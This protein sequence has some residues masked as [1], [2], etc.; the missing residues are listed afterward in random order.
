[1]RIHPKRYSWWSHR[2]HDTRTS[3]LWLGWQSTHCYSHPGRTKQ[4]KM[5]T[6]HVSDRIRRNLRQP[7]DVW[8]H[9]TDNHK[10]MW[11]WHL[12]E[13][14]EHC[15]NCRLVA[16]LML[17]IRVSLS[18]GQNWGGKPSESKA[19]KSKQLTLPVPPGHHHPQ[20]ST[21][22]QSG[23]SQAH[24]AQFLPPSAVGAARCVFQHD[25]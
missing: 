24:A 21:A 18:H 7:L 2:R 23:F 8:C 11:T 19:S 15:I 20:C 16:L 14:N 17:I 13:I 9:N 6:Y 12:H 5:G 4:A 3:C 22:V 1:M 25:S 10:Y